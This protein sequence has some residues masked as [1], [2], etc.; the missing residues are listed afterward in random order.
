MA[1]A[2]HILAIR[3]VAMSS[4]AIAARRTRLPV[5]DDDPLVPSYISLMIDPHFLATRL[6]WLLDEVVPG[7]A[8][9]RGSA[10]P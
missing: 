1:T 8:P 9:V 7:A 5:S 4:R 6:A 2:R 3:Q 10:T